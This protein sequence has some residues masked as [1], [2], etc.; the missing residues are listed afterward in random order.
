ML[1]SGTPV[2]GNDNNH[3][4]LYTVEAGQQQQQRIFSH[5]NVKEAYILIL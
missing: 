5:V 3:Y 2:F 1:N 4:W